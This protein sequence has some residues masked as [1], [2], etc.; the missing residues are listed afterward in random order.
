MTVEDWIKVTDRLPEPNELVLVVA[1]TW[2]NEP[3]VDKAYYLSSGW[4]LHPVTHWMP[5]VLPNED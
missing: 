5:I 2:H 1:K 4:T 3:Y